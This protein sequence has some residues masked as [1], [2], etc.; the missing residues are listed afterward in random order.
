M[1]VDKKTD[2]KNILT[3]G[4]ALF[5]MFFGAGNLIF[6]PYLGLT[7]G[8][9]WVF[10]F[11]CFI[12]VDAGL[13]VLALLAVF[14]SGM[15]LAGVTG[16]LGRVL[17][18]ALIVINA[19]CLGPLVCIPRTAATTFELAV[20]PL[21]PGA[22]SWIS[23]AVFFAL[24]L[25]LCLRPAKVVDIVGRILAP[26]M[27][28]AIAVLVVKGIATPI[29]TPVH[30]SDVAASVKSGLEAGY[31]TMD[32]MGALLL[33]MVVYTSIAQ[34]GYSD[35]KSQLRVTGIAGVM[36]SV[37]LFAVY[38]GL[39]YLGASASGVF[40]SDLTQAQLLLA[41]TDALLGPAGQILLGVIVAAACLTTAIGLATSCAEC[42]VSLSNGKLRYKPLII[43]VCIVSFLVSNVGLSEIISF[44]APVL[45]LIYPVL[46][47]LVILSFFDSRLRNAN[48]C[49]GA[50]LAAFMVSAYALADKY[51]ALDLGSSLLPLSG[52]G[53]AWLLPAILG[54]LAG[55]LIK[56]RGRMP[57]NTV[58][59]GG[60]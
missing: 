17:S 29:G 2:G 7:G 40:S 58:A 22:G 30:T 33:S 55:A 47:T 20:A 24:V 60:K 31:Q 37:G 8:D 50:A 41:V 12:A 43:I 52:V 34:Y 11:L 9:N 49:R 38:G 28:A 13:A 3:L 16:K 42:F 59:V 23:S 5:A 4:F 57:E 48:I 21:V 51:A 53:L 56:P 19:V 46:M 27:L 44:A 25:A 35:V 10:G 15:G 1:S 39:A 6:P 14:R 32:M 18:G 36:S 45:D 54:A 26:V